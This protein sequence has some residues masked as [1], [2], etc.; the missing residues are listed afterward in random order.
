MKKHHRGTEATES[1]EKT[2]CALP[3]FPPGGRGG[4]PIMALSVDSVA[5]VSLW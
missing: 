1:T 2:L 4:D 5:S 3:P